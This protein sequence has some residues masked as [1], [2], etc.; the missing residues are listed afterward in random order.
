MSQLSYTSLHADQSFYT[1]VECKTMELEGV[2]FV[3]NGL[4]RQS[5]KVRE[6]KRRH[7]FY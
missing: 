4:N 3:V 5:E 6:Y 1:W 2:V 7:T